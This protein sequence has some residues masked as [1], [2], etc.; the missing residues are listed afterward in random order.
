MNKTRRQIL[1]NF[2]TFYKVTI[3]KTVQEMGQI[4]A[5]RGKP[6][7]GQLTERVLSLRSGGLVFS[8]DSLARRR[9]KLDADFISYREMDQ[10]PTLKQ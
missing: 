8:I 6:G 3:T 5:L 4:W 7:H 9:M 1:L 2:K 10:T